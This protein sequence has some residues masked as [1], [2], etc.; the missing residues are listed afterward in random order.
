[1]FWR[2]ACIYEY[3]TTQD[4]LWHYVITSGSYSWHRSQSEM[5]CEHGSDLS[6]I[7]DK[8]LIIAKWYVSWNVLNQVKFEVLTPVKMS[9]LVFGVVTPCGLTGRSRYQCFGGTYCFHL[10]DVGRNF[11]T[12]LYVHTALTQ[13]TGSDV[14]PAESLAGIPRCYVT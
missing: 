11:G 4:V 12:H 8:L 6:K 10:Q 9:M 2:S 7:T 3:C 14:F 13:R 5:S 1:M